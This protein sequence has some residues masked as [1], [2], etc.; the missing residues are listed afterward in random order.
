LIVELGFVIISGVEHV[1]FYDIEQLAQQDQSRI[2]FPPIG[3][4]DTLAQGVEKQIGVGYPVVVDQHFGDLHR[5]VSEGLI[6]IGDVAIGV[7]VHFFDESF[8]LLSS[9][10]WDV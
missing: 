4:K 9:N 3:L 2:S 7:F 10:A 1:Q 5:G 8:E 6:L